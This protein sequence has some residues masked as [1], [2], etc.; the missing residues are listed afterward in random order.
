MPILEVKD[1]YKAFGGVKAVNHVSFS[2]EAGEFLG[3]IGPNGSGKSTCVN[4]ISGVYTPDSGDILYNGESIL[5]MSIA[6]RSHKGLGRT[7]QTPKP[8]LGLTVFDS[9]FTVYLQRFSYNASAKKT[10]ETLEIMELAK[11]ASMQCEKLPIE[12]RKWLDMARV[13]ATDPKVIMLDEVMAG[14]NPAEM[15]E[16]MNLVRRINQTGIAIIFIEHVMHA[17]VNLCQRIIVLED[18]ALL[19]EGEPEKVM[20]EERVIKAYLGGGFKHAESK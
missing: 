10:H 13:L 19:S 11:S 20:N 2:L 1:L 6:Q 18:G 7:F 5:H 15:T 8:F 12:K 9:V 16:S 17:V 4:L 14:L 3:L